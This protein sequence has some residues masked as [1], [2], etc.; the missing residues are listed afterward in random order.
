MKRVGVMELVK[1][2]LLAGAMV[3]AGIVYLLTNMLGIQI[4]VWLFALIGIYMIVHY[5]VNGKELH[6]N[7]SLVLGILL[8]VLG[9]Y[10]ILF[11]TY[12]EFSIYFYPVILAVAGALALGDALCLKTKGCKAW[13]Q[14]LILA[15]IQL[16]FAFLYIMLWR[17]AE[18]DFLIMLGIELILDGIYLCVSQFVFKHKCER[19]MKAEEPKVEEVEKAE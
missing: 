14:P 13:W 5:F 18:V 6:R 7:N 19:N 1:N 3:V 2:L 17:F 4:C 12:F 10:M 8:F 15:I 9:A 11:E 16:V